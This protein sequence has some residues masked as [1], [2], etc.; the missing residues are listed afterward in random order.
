MRLG[1]TLGARVR[2]SLA[3]VCLLG[4]TAASTAT[5]G[6]ITLSTNT[7]E[8]LIPHLSASVFDAT[9]FFDIT[10]LSELTL[11]VTNDTSG[12]FNDLDLST[13]VP[14]TADRARL[15]WFESNGKE[16]HL[17][18]DGSAVSD[19]GY[20][21][22]EFKNTIQVEIAC[23][24]QIVEWETDDGNVSIIVVGYEDEL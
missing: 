9:L 18:P 3:V 19:G 17:R 1:R 21:M 11:S 6:T 16:A 24:G 8:P 10:D 13:L 20:F 7:S 22:Q 15:T 12:N 14:T 4:V 2:F 5:A 23:P